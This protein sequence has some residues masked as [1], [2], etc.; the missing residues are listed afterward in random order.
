MDEMEA[1]LTA[2]ENRLRSLGSAVIAYSGGL[3]STFLA[4]VAHDVLG[5]KALAVTACSETYPL[6]EREEAV[7]TAQG[8]GLR[9]R[10]I[11]TSNLGIAGFV[12]NRADRCYYCRQELFRT[13]LRI[14]DE[15][16]LLYVMDGTTADDLSDFRPGR[17]AAGEL[18]VLSPLLEAGLKK[19]EIRIL[20]K[21][22]G[23]TNWGKPASACL[24]SRIPYHSMITEKKLRQIELAEGCL[25][26]LGLGQCRVRHHGKVAR[27]EVAAADIPR[28][29]GPLRA[30]IVSCLRAVGFIYVTVDLAGYRTGSMNEVLGA[31]GPDIAV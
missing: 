5:D 23:L 11:Q 7:E 18:G 13:L 1:K 22:L 20:S 10:L 27:I 29:C 17:R 8:I 26:S 6:R 15:E 25:R 28:V 12:E 2:L 14:A 3:D 31:S 21:R 4:K 19:T 30:E 9:H 16:G 24:A